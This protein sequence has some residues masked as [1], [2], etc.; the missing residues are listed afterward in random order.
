M[1]ILRRANEAAIHR[2]V[3]EIDAEKLAALRAEKVLSLQEL[4]DFSGVPL[5]TIWRLEK[6]YG[7]QTSARQS[8]IRKLASALDIEPRELVR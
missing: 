5:N 2:G 3:P 7:G 4:S 8:T 1:G 6:A